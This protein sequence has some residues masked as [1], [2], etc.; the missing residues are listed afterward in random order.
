MDYILKI[1]YMVLNDAWGMQSQYQIIV[2]PHINLK[3]CLNI[4]SLQFSRSPDLSI[5]F[6]TCLPCKWPFPIFYNLEDNCNKNY[7]YCCLWDIF[8]A[9]TLQCPTSRSN[10]DVFFLRQYR[11]LNEKLLIFAKSW[12]LPC[13]IS[14]DY[15]DHRRISLKV[16][17]IKNLPKVK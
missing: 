10:W 4:V 1:W 12:Q 16:P 3:A 15:S 2:W 14:L 9:W 13:F 8:P 7:K 6:I 5:Q 11:T 17:N